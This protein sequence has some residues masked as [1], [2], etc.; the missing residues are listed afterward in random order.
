MSIFPSYE[1]SR[2][3]TRVRA[4]SIKFDFLFFVL[5]NFRVFVIRFHLEFAENEVTRRFTKTL[6]FENTKNTAI[7]GLLCECLQTPH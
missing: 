6:K 2:D 3:F 4:S 1:S 5:S 7:H